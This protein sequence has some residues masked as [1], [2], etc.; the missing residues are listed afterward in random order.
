MTLRK[1]RFVGKAV[2]QTS[3]RKPAPKYVKIGKNG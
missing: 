2:G 1:G 3:I